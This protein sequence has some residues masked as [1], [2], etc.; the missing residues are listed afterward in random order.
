MVALPFQRRRLP[1]FG[2]MSAPAAQ[3]G[4]AWLRAAEDIFLLLHRK[5]PEIQLTFQEA[6]WRCR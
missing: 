5:L 6:V 1:A 3:G 2:S 4:V